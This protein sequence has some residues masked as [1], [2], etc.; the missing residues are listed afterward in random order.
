VLQDAGATVVSSG[1]ATE[2]VRLVDLEI[3]DAVVTDLDMPERDGSGYS[4]NF[5][6]GYPACRS[7][8]YRDTSSNSTYSASPS[9]FPN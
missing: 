2:A 8:Q 1:R 9:V 5:P 4:V 3:P 6:V 7:L